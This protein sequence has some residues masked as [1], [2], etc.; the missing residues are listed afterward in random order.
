MLQEKLG[1]IA[2]KNTGKV[3]VG[4]DLGDSFSQISFCTTGSEETETVSSVAGTEQYNIPTLLCKRKDVNQW[5]Y[6]REA[7]KYR[8]DSNCIP[9]ENLVSLAEA[10][11]QV[12]VGEDSFDAVALLTLFVKRSLS[13]LSMS[14]AL[15]RIEAVMFTVADLSPRIIDVLG[16]VS[17]GLQLKTS[18]VF[19][20]SHME[21]FYYFM[22][23]QPAELRKNGILI[24]DYSGE[25]E[26]YRLECNR[27]T[28]PQV[29]FIH[30]QKYPQIQRMQWSEEE[31]GHAEK[32]QELDRMFVQVLEECCKEVV[33]STAYLLGDG[34][35]DDWAVESLRYLC[36]G[37]R[38]FQG[39]NLYSKGACYGARERLTPS[40]AGKA[41]VFLGEDKLK[42]NIGM[43]VLR[44]G[45]QT[46][47]AMMD[48]GVNWYEVKADFEIILE[49]G[50][51]LSLLI[52]SLT[53]GEV[54]EKVMVL[55]GLPE[56][57]KRTTRLRIHVEM[58]SAEQVVATVEDLGF[59]ELFAS[60]G[61][62]WTQTFTVV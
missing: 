27:R 35:K 61:K 15:N 48:A 25:L 57:P 11:E 60:S 46:Y 38:V 2:K 20:Q 1:E 36:R 41:S 33:I 29:V 21:S 43:Q 42:A 34:F 52:T 23:Y 19:F 40:E 8:N 55:E 51:T 7:M 17:A 58:S 10:G 24:C 32:K 18:H 56:R 3:I 14:V 39:N 62:G 5:F 9:V 44:Q 54:V 30:K 22:L 47:Y 4:Y 45:K 28:V 16:Q 49:S 31:A 37:R 12:Q 53:G 26:T 6:G 50:H 59:G 13:L